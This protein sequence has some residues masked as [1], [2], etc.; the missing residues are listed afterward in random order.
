MVLSAED[1]VN[2][3]PVL[4]HIEP[5]YKLAL[6]AYADKEGISLSQ[7]GAKAIR[8]LIDALCRA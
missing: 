6:K 1:R 7:A 3:V 5:D 2:K 4:I 8:Y